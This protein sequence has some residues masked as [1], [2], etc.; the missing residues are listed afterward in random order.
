M[1]RI[2]PC[3]LISAALVAAAPA[4]AAAP[5]VVAGW[6]QSVQ[7]PGSLSGAIPFYD[8]IGGRTIR[9][10]VRPTLDGSAM[11]VRLS[12]LLGT[13]PLTI[14]DARVA[15]S[16]AQ[17]AATGPS[18]RLTFSGRTRVTIPP[19]RQIASDLVPFDVRAQRNMA[20]SLYAPG[21]TGPATAGGSLFHT[22]YVSEPGDVA[23]NPSSA[24][25][26]TL[27]KAWYFVSGVDVVPR[28][29][30]GTVVVIG[31]SITTGYR[32]TPDAYQGWVDVLGR[33]LH[34]NRRTRN[35]A[36]VNAGIAGNTL[37]EDTGCYG[38]S[39]V[40]RLDRDAL[41]QPGV[42]T[43]VVAV[44]SNDLTQPNQTDD[45]CAAHTPVSA[46]DMIALYSQVLRR[47]R[48]RHLTGILATIP[49]F[50]HYRYWSADIEQR[51]EAINTWMRASKLS[52]GVID[53][54]AVLAD[55][56]DPTVLP[57]GFD[58]GDG[59]HPNDAGH[60][61]LGNQIPLSLFPTPRP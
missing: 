14:T 38:Q 34:A 60:A 31:A 50:G 22:N 5:K 56:A 11:R 51:R 10:V 13:Q 8:D 20:V 19:G 46:A 2:A 42:R 1:K 28:R 23:S 30:A 27:A 54:D 4:Q 59:L 16:G 52:D 24:P 45:A 33:R 32:S 37:H 29:P 43:V 57:A 40:H 39:V 49:P 48:A 17:A 21:P 9:N 47:I 35:L 3:V 58:S 25:F 12:N 61:A 55:P 7:D 6:A 15:R 18:R 53:E 41:N 36:V 44:G 26:S